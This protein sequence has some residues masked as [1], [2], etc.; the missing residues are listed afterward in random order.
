MKRTIILLVSI[1]WIASAQGQKK[2]PKASL[3]TLPVM[4]LP[5]INQSAF[6]EGEY[7]RF[8][9]HYGIIDAGEA[10]L[11]VYKAKKKFVG[12]EALHVVGKGRT[13]GMFNWFFKVKDRYET[14]LDEDGIFP[15]E[16]VRDI[17]EGGYEKYQT[18]RFHQENA[19]VTTN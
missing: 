10:E 5:D 1:I 13:L 11:T 9:L 14:Y 12:R 19:A 18:Y 4:D 15:W 6:G 2:P 7:L 8:R 3:D 17:N 16:F